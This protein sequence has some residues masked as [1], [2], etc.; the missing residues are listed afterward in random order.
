MG[1]K[2]LRSSC[3]AESPASRREHRGRETVFDILMQ[4]Q[5][6]SVEL[7]QS[8][9]IGTEEERSCLFGIPSNP[10]LVRWPCSLAVFSEILDFSLESRRPIQGFALE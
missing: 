1:A 9:A 6:L 3:D 8:V 2:S 7:K 4:M 10:P 5:I